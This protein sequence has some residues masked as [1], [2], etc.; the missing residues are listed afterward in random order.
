MATE[1]PFHEFIFQHLNSFGQE[2]AGFG[3]APRAAWAATPNWTSDAVRGD[4][5]SE[6]R[7]GSSHVP[8]HVFCLITKA[9]ADRCVEDAAFQRRNVWTMIS[10]CAFQHR[11]VSVRNRALAGSSKITTHICTW[12]E[13]RRKGTEQHRTG[14]HAVRAKRC[15]DIQSI[16]REVKFGAELV[17]MRRASDDPCP[18]AV[19][20]DLGRH[21]DTAD[22]HDT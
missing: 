15:R 3:G 1:R 10:R 7:C 19:L 11:T 22:R 13:R 20:H 8:A 14:P 6:V 2:E 18:A 17:D 4:S 5:I 16:V 9:L 21:R 12:N